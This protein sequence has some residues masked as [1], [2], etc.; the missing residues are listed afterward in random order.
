MV[1]VRYLGT[2]EAFDDRLPNTSLVYEGDRR[3]LLDCGYSIP[4]ALWK[5]SLD[6]GWLD[7]IYLTH[8]HADHCFGLPAVLARMNQDGRTRSL[9]LLGGVGSTEASKAVLT[10]GYPSLL[11]RLGFALEY[12]IS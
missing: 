9:Q 2:G 1:Q 12:I 3:I 8:F 5:Q 6:P 4:H 10:L 7:A 11:G